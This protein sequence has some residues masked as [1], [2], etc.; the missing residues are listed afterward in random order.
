MFFFLFLELIADGAGPPT[1]AAVGPCS[2][3]FEGAERKQEQKEEAFDFP[4]SGQQPAAENKG[5]VRVSVCVCVRLIGRSAAYLS[6]RLLLCRGSA[7][8][9]WLAGWPADRCPRGASGTPELRTLDL[10]RA[11][12]VS[13]PKR[14]S[15]QEACAVR[16]YRS[17]VAALAAAST[18]PRRRRRRRA[19]I[20]Q[21]GRFCTGRC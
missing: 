6:W 14:R 20:L 3:S 9:S 7:L 12:R 8:R 10:C 1:M 13:L 5:R 4:I 2:C 19:S 16:S 21:R 18:I 11:R 15:Y 17:S